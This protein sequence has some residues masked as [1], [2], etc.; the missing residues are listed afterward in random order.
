MPSQS[1]KK[2]NAIES[3]IYIYIS[4]VKKARHVKCCLKS[5]PLAINY[6]ISGN[7]TLIEDCYGWCLFTRNTTKL[8]PSMRSASKI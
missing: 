5:Q 2:L 4:K 6:K 7:I 3:Y 8:N 1:V